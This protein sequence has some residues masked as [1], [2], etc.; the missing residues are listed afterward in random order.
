IGISHGETGGLAPDHAATEEI[1]RGSGAAW[2]MLRNSIYMNGVVQEAA[3][4]LAAGRVS[5]PAN[6]ARI[7]YVTREDGAAAGAA[8]PAGGRARESRLR[9]HGGRGRRPA[10]DRAR[11]DRGDGRADR[12]RRRAGGAAVAVRQPGRRDAE[13]RLRAA[14]RPSADDGA[15]VSRS[16]SRRAPQRRSSARLIASSTGE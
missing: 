5:V 14:H 2:T 8:G 16:A 7:T 10:G 13:R 4:M 11:R 12:D 1:L 9:H 6:A 3:A 15:R